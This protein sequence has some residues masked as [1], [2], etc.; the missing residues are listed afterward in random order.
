[1]AVAHVALDLGL[2]HQRRHRVDDH[3][4]DR[5]RAHQRLADVQRLFAVVRLR[6]IQLVDVHAQLFGIHRI[7]RVLGVDEGR[8]AAHLLRLGDAVQRH[9][10]LAGGFRPVDLHDAPLGQAAHAKR[11]VQLQ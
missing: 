6:H 11:K 2:G 3:D 9:R 1:M 7:Q 5:A 8:R 4:V 10:G